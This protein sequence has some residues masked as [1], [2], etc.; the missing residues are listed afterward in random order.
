MKWRYARNCHFEQAFSSVPKVKKQTD[1]KSLNSL[2][3]SPETEAENS[4]S[5]VGKMKNIV[6]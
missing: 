6:V 1:G 2:K 5:M 4:L 3:A